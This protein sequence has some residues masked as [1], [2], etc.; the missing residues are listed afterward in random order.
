V[1]VRAVTLRAYRVTAPAPDTA[2]AAASVSTERFSGALRFPTVSTQESSAF[3]PQPFLALHEFL[4]ISF[5]RVHASLEREVVGGYSLLYTWRGSDTS[6]API[7]LMGHLDVVPVESGTETSWKH[8]PFEGTVADGFIWGR[9][10]LD[11]KSAAL[12]VLEA[13][14]LLLERG[15]RPR[16]TI[17]VAFGHDEELGGFAGARAM[18]ALI[19]QRS[20]RLEFLLDEGGVIAGE[21]LIPGVTRRAALVGVVEKA[22]LNVELTVESTGGHSSMPPSHTAVGVLSRAITRLEENQMPARLTPVS[23]A[24]FVRL[25]PEMPFA[26]RLLMANLWLFRPLVLSVLAREPSTAAT[27]RTTT[28]ATMMNGSPK[29]NVLPIKARAIVNFRILPGETAADVLAHVRRVVADSTVQVSVSGTP[30]DPSPVADYGSPQFAVLEQTIVQ[31]FPD[32]VPV[33]FLMVGGTDTRHYESLTRNVFRFNPFVA[34]PEMI[35][36]A[37]GTNER[38]RAGDFARGV[39]FY[40]QLILNSDGK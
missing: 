4:R 19:R 21:G 29:A 10:A 8:Q 26:R 22:T 35:S 25:A 31:L 20:G 33:P 38:I 7:L 37:H 13:V 27:V 34:T 15:F 9:G 11:D 2:I 23:E 1:A 3:D 5:P 36:G 18:A 32:V 30:N 16:H 12:G 17:Y 40:A 24:M 14:E 28:A 6:L 39:Q